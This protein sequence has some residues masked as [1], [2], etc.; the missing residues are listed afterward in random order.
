VEARPH[1]PSVR[2]ASDHLRLGRIHKLV[3]ISCLGCFKMWYS[4]LTQAGRRRAAVPALPQSSTACFPAA[5]SRPTPS[6]ASRH[7]VARLPTPVRT[8]IGWVTCC[9]HCLRARGWT[10]TA[11]RSDPS[12]FEVILDRPGRQNCQSRMRIDSRLDSLPVLPTAA[13][14]C[15][16]GRGCH[17]ARVSIP[18]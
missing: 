17:L 5:E 7:Q 1:P 4:G 6:W 16:R 14:S 9:L 11:C 2:R 18:G 8:S 3:S 10:Q 13:H 15:C 12:I